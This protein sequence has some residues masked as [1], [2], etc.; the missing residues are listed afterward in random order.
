MSSAKSCLQKSM[1]TKKTKK[2]KEREKLCVFLAKYR[3]G[4]M[5]ILRIF[6]INYQHFPLV[7]VG[8]CG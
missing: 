4:G 6:Y 2:K 3:K 5:T 1:P 8:F 7:C